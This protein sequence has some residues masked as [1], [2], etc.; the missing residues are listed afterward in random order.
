MERATV[1]LVIAWESVSRRVRLVCILAYE[2]QSIDTGR[3]RICAGRNATSLCA[4]EA[5]AKIKHIQSEG[6]AVS[7]G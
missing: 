2:V 6:E 4:G 7:V 1:P 3:G 5:E